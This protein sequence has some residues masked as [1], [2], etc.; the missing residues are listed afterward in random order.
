MKWHV[1]NCDVVSSNTKMFVNTIKGRR[2][3]QSINQKNPLASGL[4]HFFAL[5][6]F[7]SPYKTAP[8]STSFKQILFTSANERF[9]ASLILHSS[10]S[11]QESIN[12]YVSWA[13]S[14]NIYVLGKSVLIE[15]LTYDAM[16]H[17]KPFLDFSK[18]LK[19]LPTWLDDFFN[20]KNNITKL[21][22]ANYPL[23]NSN[24]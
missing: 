14:S 3:F 19:I 9:R 4:L 6:R 23:V 20:P 15:F 5:E 1:V 21:D 7:H 13:V 17:C 2:A 24:F 16:L 8:Y 22:K 11:R 18:K 12:V 10:I